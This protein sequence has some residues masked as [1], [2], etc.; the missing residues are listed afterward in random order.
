MA[1]DDFQQFARPKQE[2]RIRWLAEAFIAER[3]SFINKDSVI[4]DRVDDGGKQRP[5]EIVGYDDPGK[6]PARKRPWLPVLQIG[7]DSFDTGQVSQGVERFPIAVERNN[8]MATCRQG[9]CVAATAAGNVEDRAVIGD[10]RRESDDPWR[11]ARIV[12]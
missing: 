12:H 8:G 10:Q 6:P 3:E 9:A 1:T 5:V 4:G 2:I 11:G 7:R